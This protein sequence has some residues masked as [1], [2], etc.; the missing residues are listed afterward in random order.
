MERIRNRN[1]HGRLSPIG[2][3]IKFQAEQ[4]SKKVDKATNYG[5]NNKQYIKIY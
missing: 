5:N 3:N 4:L 1:S 2:N